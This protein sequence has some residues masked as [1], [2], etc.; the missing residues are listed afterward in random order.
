MPNN[1]SAVL[2]T[3]CITSFLVP[4][5]G[6]ALNLALPDIG[7]AFGLDVKQLGW[8][9][10][11]F[12]IATAMFQV[13]LAKIADLIGR[14]KMFLWGVAFF[15]V[16][17][18]ACAFAWDFTSLIMFRV[19]SGIG[20][21]MVFS[22]N[23]AILSA[24]YEPHERGAAMGIITSVVYLALA[25]GPFFGG[26]LTHYLGWESVFYIPGAILVVQAFSVPF[27]IK[28]EWITHSDKKFDKFGSLIYGLALFCLIFGFSEFSWTLM[29]AGILLFIFFYN[30]EKKKEEPVL[31]VRLFGSNKV[32]TFASLAAFLSYAA[33]MAVF[34]M[35]SLYLQFERGFDA[36]TAG[37]IFIASALVQS[38]SA[39]YAGKLA[40]KFEASKIAMLGMGLNSI[41]L[42]GLIFVGVDTPIFVIIAMLLF[43]GLGIGLFCSP[44]TKVIMGSVENRFM[45][46]ASA[47]VGTM[48]LAGQALS[49][50]IAIMSVSLFGNFMQSWMFTFAIC[51]L[52]CLIGV[53]AS[54][55]NSIFTPHGK[56]FAKEEKKT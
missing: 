24:T 36:R 9:N 42:L 35:M 27:L 5:M 11:A 28:Q 49:M 14:K 55:V 52:L 2:F 32:F 7:Q 1:K 16:S 19:F 34:F 4:Y 13:P 20:A 25:L 46:Q 22:T 3:L 53:Y 40:D 15:G 38:V 48:R 50:G 30:Y 8:V 33:T 43:L 31:Q 18:V 17:S 10:S 54:S 51:A 21:A 56:S 29:I 6:S 41:G 45:S 23:L 39:L 12:L 47:T 26:M 44:N 37:F